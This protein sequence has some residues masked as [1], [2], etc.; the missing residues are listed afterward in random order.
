MHV[1]LQYEWG[2]WYRTDLNLKAKQ[3]ESNFAHSNT[4]AHTLTRVNTIQKLVN[5]QLKA[6]VND[7]SRIL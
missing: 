4:H 7:E 6:L 3:I 5:S 2:T 1:R